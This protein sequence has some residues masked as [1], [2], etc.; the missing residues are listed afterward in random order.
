M[1]ASCSAE[2]HLHA[3]SYWPKDMPSLK[4]PHKHNCKQRQLAYYLPGKNYTHHSFSVIDHAELVGTLVSSPNIARFRKGQP[5]YN[6]KFSCVW[7]QTNVRTPYFVF[8]F[9]RSFESKIHKTQ[10]PVPWGNVCWT[11]AKWDRYICYICFRTYI[12]FHVSYS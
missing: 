9:E 1:E 3:A 5:V 2:H 6:H 4:D 10:F 12:P 7:P 8:N 11:T